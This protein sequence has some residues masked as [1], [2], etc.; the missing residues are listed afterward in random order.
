MSKLVVIKLGEGSLHD[1]FSLVIAQYWETSNSLPTQFTGSLPS[2][3]KIA[4]IYKRYQLIH[5]SLYQ[6][7]TKRTG[8]ELESS[9]L[10]NV[11]VVDFTEI[12]QQLNRALNEWLNSN[13]FRQIDQQL[14][15][16]IAIDDEVH[17]IF[18]TSNHLLQHL[19]WHLWHFFEDYQRAE[20][21]LSCPRYERVKPQPKKYFTNKVRVLA[22]LGNSV[23][24]DV[25]KDRE[26]LEKLPDSSTTFLVEPSREE[27]HKYL[28]DEKGWHILYFAG[29]SHSQDSQG[30]IH[31]NQNTAL[32]IADLKYALT[33][34][35]KQGGLKLA[36]FNSCDGIKLIEQLADLQITQIIVMRLNIADKVAQEFLK[37]FFNFFAIKG[38]PFYIA[39]RYAR[40]SLQGLEDNYPG[41]SLIPVTCQNLAEESL[42][43]QGMKNSSNNV[44]L[45]LLYQP[46]PKIFISLLLTLVTP[47]IAHKLLF[48]INTSLP[49]SSFQYSCDN[50][51]ISEKKVLAECRRRD[52][53]KNSA[54][55]SIP[56]INNHDGNLT[57][58]GF[59][60]SSN[61]HFDNECKNISILK[62]RISGDC[63]KNNG[64]YNKTSI[65]LPSV[66]NDDGNL[67]IN[68]D[69]RRNFSSCFTFRMPKHP[70]YLCSYGVS[71]EIEENVPN[72][73]SS[74]IDIENDKKK[75]EDEAKK[76]I[77][78]IFQ[79]EL[80]RNATEYE[81]D[82]YVNYYLQNL[83]T[84]NLTIAE[85]T[86]NIAKTSSLLRNGNV[87]SLSC[88][89]HISNPNHK[90]FKGN[91]EN[92][93]VSL[94]SETGAKFPD[95]KW[96]IHVN[97]N[98]TIALENK[99]GTGSYRWLNGQTDS[100]IGESGTVNLDNQRNS[101]NKSKEW[102]VHIVRYGDIMLENQNKTGNSVW[103]NGKTH[104]GGINLEPKLTRET[105]GTRWRIIK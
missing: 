29:H 15:T 69:D 31:I 28:S 59:N 20:V 34:A 81:L 24:I 33:F 61:F 35:V 8:I 43:W 25:Q 72:S 91:T 23:G 76:V 100:F 10:N 48:N 50:I 38:E 104:D 39:M 41:A 62:N 1:G 54:R 47:L 75:N 42:S 83:A 56:G 85:I 98:G 13:S 97:N 74:T 55:I 71:S 52:G 103:L 78:S 37:Y 7:R 3:S 30:I 2:M 80:K 26:F 67:I 105:T 6:N 88:E 90:W 68:E 21:G 66:T 44:L 63:R 94:F 18:E 32:T 73:S 22:V 11:S 60:N 9:G 17:V 27:L 82:S 87:I 36:I 58:T 92:G 16:R 64:S 93:T 14:R 40:Q 49:S 101:S 70:L 96:K 65:L 84:P 51:S 102:K 77:N 4:D 12:Q 86:D 89:G 95:T 5:E 45:S 79:K 99:S 53:S 57:F 46:F 19:P